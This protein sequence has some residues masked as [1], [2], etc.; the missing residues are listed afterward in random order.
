MLHTIYTLTPQSVNVLA[1]VYTILYCT[2]CTDS[3]AGDS[4][5]SDSISN[6]DDNSSVIKPLLVR[7][8]DGQLHVNFDP[9]L[10]NMLRE[11]HHHMHLYCVMHF[12]SYAIT[13]APKATLVHVFLVSLYSYFKCQF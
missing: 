6:S 9:V 2:V 5:S 4:S 11:V 8:N 10:T 1:Y 12:V 3:Q 7:T 13:F